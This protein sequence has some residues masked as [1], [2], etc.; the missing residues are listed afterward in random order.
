M[1]PTA[2]ARLLALLSD[3]REHDMRECL[4]IAGF[5]Y[6]GRLHELRQEGHVVETIQYSAN[7]FGYR[8][9]VKARQLEL[10]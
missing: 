1:R 5:R 2:K 3:G 4:E 6:G 8:L 9:V 10:V 7:H